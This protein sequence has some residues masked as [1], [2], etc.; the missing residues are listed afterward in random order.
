MLNILSVDVEDYFH[1]EAF[2][3]QISPQD[4]DRFESRV[5]RNTYRILEIFAKHNAKATFFMLGWVAEKFPR[6]AR[7][8]AAAGHEIGSHGFGHRR[9][10]RLTPKEFAADIA[11]SK[12][13]LV[14]QVQRPVVCYRAPS[15][16]VVKN[17]LWTLD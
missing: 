5:E 3:S 17:T 14:Q 13:A 12:N 10:D 15:F 6:L 9:L 11:R 4:W 2:A 16:S 8:I 1:V 7:E